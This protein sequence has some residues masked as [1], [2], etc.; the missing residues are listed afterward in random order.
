MLNGLTVSALLKSVIVL[1]AIGVVAI[2]SVN[3]WD[4]WPGLGSTRRISLI[5]DAS[6]NLFKAMHNLR[7]DRSTTSRILNGESVIQPD[8]EKYLRTIQDN[9][10]PPLRSATKLL[11]SI[12]FVDKPTLLLSLSQLAEKLTAGQTQAWD[13]MRKPK[14]SPP[15]P[16]S[17]EY[18]ETTPTFL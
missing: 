17:K 5:A 15:P 6:S 10:M 7:N 3:A 2:L 14:V 8:I 11:V 18:N 16:L 12:D 4:S 1:L 13:A 9:E